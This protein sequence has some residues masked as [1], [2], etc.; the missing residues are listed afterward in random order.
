[1]CLAVPALVEAV[2]PSANT[3]QV[4]RNGGLATISLAMLEPDELP[5]AGDYV[6]V[7]YG[8]AMER[9]SRADALATRQA[10]EDLQAGLDPSV[11]E[12]SLESGGVEP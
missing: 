4:H 1:M 2:D 9:M 3:A 6:I 8:Y 11:F 7:Q 12:E 10:I 5:A